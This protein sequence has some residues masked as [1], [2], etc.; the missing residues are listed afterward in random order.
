VI[1]S[2]ES[3]NSSTNNYRFF[4][5]TIMH[6]HGHGLG[7][8]HVCPINSTKLMEPLLATV[9]DGPQQDELRAVQANYG[10]PYE[11]NDS[12]ATASPLGVIA[13]GGTI[14]IGTVPAPAIANTAILSLTPVG[15]AA[16][17]FS[18]TIDAP[19]LVDFTVTPVGSSYSDWDQT[20]GCAT[21]GPTSNALTQADLIVTAYAANGTTPWRS[22]NDNIVGQAE[23]ISDL[24]MSPAGT[25]FVKVSAAAAPAETQMYR[26]FVN[27]NNTALA[28]NAS[29]GTFP[30]FVRITWPSI[31]D[32][33]NYQVVRNTVNSTA[34][35]SQVGQGTATTFDDMTAVPST[36]YFYFVRALQP[37]N[38]AYRFLN[39]VGA[40]G[41][42]GSTCGT[43]DFNGDGDVG[44]DLD[45]EAFFACMAGS[46]C[47]TC[48]TADFNNDG[49]TG[50]DLDI[51]AFFRVL[52]GGS[53]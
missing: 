26:L 23:S 47:A 50:T 22:Q 13:A 14:S 20:G 24:L 34:G 19:R 7:F 46:C 36:P 10:D 52:G 25:Y 42:A 49:D 8:E 53:C 3:W 28:P 15:D 35:A 4:R 44:T 1:D 17:Y 33:T 43:A 2:T 5:N 12:A 31:A 51:E 41:F 21:S 11:A 29:D 45:I 6:E 32:A 18:F 27:V 38:F 16:D 37:G 30:G 39:T 9:F 40:T 48:F